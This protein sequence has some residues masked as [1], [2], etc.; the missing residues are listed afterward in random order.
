[1]SE[2]LQATAGSVPESMVSPRK[3]RIEAI[4]Q[5]R[6]HVFL[7]LFPHPRRSHRL[8]MPAHA[9]ICCRWEDFGNASAFHILEKYKASIPSF[10]DDIEGTASVG[11]MRCVRLYPCCRSPRQCYPPRTDSWPSPA[12]TLPFR[13]FLACRWWLLASSPPPRTCPACPPWLTAPTSSTERVSATQSARMPTRV[14][15]NTRYATS[16]VRSCHVS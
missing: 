4:T 11:A 10:N 1:M 13:L 9:N 3:P 8:R 6:P 16:L 14:G 12:P 5:S 15:A 7:P 2:C